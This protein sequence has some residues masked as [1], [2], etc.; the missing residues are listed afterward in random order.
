M[1]NLQS[2]QCVFMFLKSINI[3]I[4]YRVYIYKIKYILNK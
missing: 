1:A 2:V 3:N 4:K